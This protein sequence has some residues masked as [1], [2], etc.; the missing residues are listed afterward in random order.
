MKF[1][2]LLLLFCHLYHMISF[3]FLEAPPA[4]ITHSG[5]GLDV[6]ICKHHSLI[7]HADLR[8][9]DHKT[10]TQVGL[11]A[12]KEYLRCVALVLFAE[13]RER[14]PLDRLGDKRQGLKQE[15]KSG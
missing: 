13:I 15:N 7:L 1:L 5:V 10:A 9:R 6:C 4:S 3:L 14:G 2:W 12:S 11:A 8:Y